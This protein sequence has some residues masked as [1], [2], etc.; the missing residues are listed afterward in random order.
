MRRSRD[1]WLLWHAASQR[2]APRL[3]PASRTLA[4]ADPAN[5]AG[6]IQGLP[7]VRIVP[8]YQSGQLQVPRPQRTKAAP[9][10][11][12]TMFARR[13]TAR[14]AVAGVKGACPLGARSEERRVGKEC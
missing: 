6:F 2:G 10:M 1:L 9:S 11:N 5:I 12:D 14:G 13:C 4:V 7:F 8:D 3:H